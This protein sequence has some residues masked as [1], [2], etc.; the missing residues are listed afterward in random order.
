[1]NLV[2]LYVEAKGENS[3]LSLSEFYSTQLSKTNCKQRE[4]ALPSRTS[5]CDAYNK[6]QRGVVLRARGRNGLLS[7]AEI[8]E[9]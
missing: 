8:D 2:N 7:S 4:N 3:K 9:L 1:M 5:F 6:F